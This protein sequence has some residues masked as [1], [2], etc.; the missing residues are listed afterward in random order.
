MACERQEAFLTKDIK[1]G[2]CHG[3]HTAMEKDLSQHRLQRWLIIST[4]TDQSIVPRPLTSAHHFHS[5][6][7]Q[8]L[9]PFSCT[10]WQHGKE[11]CVCFQRGEKGDVEDWH[12]ALPQTEHTLCTVSGYS[13]SFLCS[14]DFLAQTPLRAARACT[15]LRGKEGRE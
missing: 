14:V 11:R 8:A 10:Y 13:L 2:L 4:S 12:P 3:T 15:G 1:P 9:N 5:K 6:T 7:Q